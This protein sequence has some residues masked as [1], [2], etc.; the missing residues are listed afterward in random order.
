VRILLANTRHFRRGGDS[1]YTFGLAD[2]LRGADHEVGFIAMAGPHNEPD[3][4]A[5]LF[6]SHVDFRELNR[7]KSVATG[8]HVLRR[9]IFSSEAEEKFTKL[10]ARFRPD[11]VH[12][13]N[14]HAHLTPSIVFAAS[15][16]GIP[17]VWTMHDYKLMCP[18]SHFRVDETGA[19][20][21]ACRPGQYHW[22]VVKRCKKDS[23]LASGM[24]AVE[25]Y[26][27]WARGLRSR[28]HTF[29]C[30]SRFLAG[31][32]LEHGWR[33]EN[34]RHVPNFIDAGP[35]PA[36]RGE[37]KHFLFVG[38][39][40]ALKGV[41][42]LLDAAG[43]LNGAQVL[44]VGECDDPGIRE[45]LGRLPSDVQYLGPKTRQEIAALLADARAL[46]IPS[47]WYEN[48][49]MVILEAFAAGVPVVGS[50]IGGIPELV[51]HEERGLLV[52]AGSAH[53]LAQAIG[54]LNRD[55]AKAK[56]LGQAARE[57]VVRHHSVS[58]HL[59]SVTEI[60]HRAIQSKE[61]PRE[62]AARERQASW[63]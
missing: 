2:A 62:T 33:S 43:Q 5:D 36:P 30:P 17:V 29:L 52:E 32:M 4:N 40:E 23:L 7:K 8:L 39:M 25:A 24:A 12:L 54:Q 41:D 42:T 28:V 26:A 58:G 11:V 9:S 22:A 3:P 50:D 13:Q 34:V 16:V 18:N 1:T 10:V 35:T 46:V 61:R 59:E 19:L 6:V 37:G 56:K 57:Y 45:R 47:L 60:Y 44:L 48:Q 38:K 21:E 55:A 27:H 63:I 15:R 31:K 51:A 14:I 53:A 49:P 20:C